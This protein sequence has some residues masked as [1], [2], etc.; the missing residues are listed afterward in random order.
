MIK[1]DVKIKY[2][3]HLRIKSTILFVGR[4]IAPSLIWLGS[5]K[6]ADSVAGLGVVC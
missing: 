1:I 3:K 4:I 6:R 2:N 5:K